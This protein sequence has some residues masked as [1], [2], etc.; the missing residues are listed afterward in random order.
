MRILVIGGSGV[1]STAVTQQLINRGDAVALFNR[2][3]TPL[4]F[5]G[6]AELLKGD[7]TDHE[8]VCRAISEAGPWDCVIDMICSAPEDAKSLARAC[9]G[10][11][12]Q[13]IFCSTTNVY[14][15]PA[16]RYPVKP[17]HR[18]GAAFKNGVDKAECEAIHRVAA[19]RGD[20]AITIIR[21][22]QS[23]GEGGGVLNSLKASSSY[24]DRMRKRKPV[25]VH[26]DGTGLW[27]ALHVHDAAAAFVAAAGSP[28]A[29]GKTY[30]ATGEEWMT[31]DQYNA[32]VAAAMGVPC[33]RLVHVPL[34][35]LTKLAPERAA[36][37]A[38]SL[39]YPGIYDTADTRRDLGVQQTVSLVEGMERTIRWIEENEGIAPWESDRDYDRII[40]VWEDLLDGTC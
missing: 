8:A 4:R 7:R 37:A 21:P 9:R 10:N 30:N 34:E 23:Y 14:P 35:V 2:G 20:Y 36:Q 26:G 6:E 33:P 12:K 40:R 32:N 1:I 24:L 15:K 27:S 17:D 39:Q 18:L 28:I 29:F 25:V 13:V 11:A 19:E 31:W 3:R 16:D 22:G 38:R 5:S